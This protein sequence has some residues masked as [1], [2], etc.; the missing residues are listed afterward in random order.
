MVFT[1]DICAGTT[2]DG[3]C[4]YVRFRT[5]TDRTNQYEHSVTVGC[6]ARVAAVRLKESKVAPE[7]ESWE[8]LTAGSV[9]FES[10]FSRSF[11]S[12][13]HLV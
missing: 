8:I 1:C 3:L 9:V 7:R 5:I 12:C 2:L 4:V 11:L 6:V 13:L 10:G